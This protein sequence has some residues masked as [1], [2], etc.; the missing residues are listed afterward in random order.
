MFIYHVVSLLLDMIEL[1][2]GS[3]RVLL[4]Y[5]LNPHLLITSTTTAILLENTST[6][7]SFMSSGMGSPEE[8]NC[9]HVVRFDN[10]CVLI[11]KTTLSR[12]KLPVV[13]TKSYSL[14]L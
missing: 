14:P 13:L 10:E 4:F 11:P 8:V 1:V 7:G 3:I 12:S 6:M 5:L 9:S 2:S